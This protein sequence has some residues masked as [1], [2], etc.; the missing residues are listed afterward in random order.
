MRAFEIFRAGRH[1]PSQ[2][3]GP[4]TFSEADMATAAAAYDPALHEAPLVVGHPKSDA[5]AYGW[6]RS[7]SATGGVLTAT[8]AQVAPEFAELVESGR[9]KKRSASFYPPTHD[10]NPKPGTWYLRHVGFLGAQPPSLK[11]LRD[12]TFSDD[13]D[14]CVTV[15]FG[16][17]EP[18]ADVRLLSRLLAGVRQL[19]TSDAAFAEAPT[20]TTTEEEPAVA[21]D[22]ASARE[23]ELAAREEAIKSR[24]AEFAE[25]SSAIAKQRAEIARADN[26]AFLARLVGEG[27]PLPAAEDALLSFMDG[28]SA[29]TVEFAEGGETKAVPPLQFFR[30]VLA[31]LPKQVAFGEHAGGADGAGDDPQ[32]ISDAAIAFQEEQRGKGITVDIATAVRKV[33]AR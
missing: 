25:Q 9:Y 30:D 7:L 5:P 1:T 21:D 33:T 24:E 6:V 20:T 14:G 26:A 13:S 11:G 31:R 19:L 3:G 29:G 32:A 18:D 16:E 10:A 2:G 4:L 27:K 17:A 12:V 15:E 28:L 8:P 23:A 22:T